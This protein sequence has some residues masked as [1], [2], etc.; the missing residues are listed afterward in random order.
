MEDN[1][2]LRAQL[3]KAEADYNGMMA[4]EGSRIDDLRDRLS[5]TLAALNSL[6]AKPEVCA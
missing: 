1:N 3:A 2:R 4:L 5:A 6:G